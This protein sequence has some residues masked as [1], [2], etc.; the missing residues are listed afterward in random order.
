MNSLRI[1]NK[2]IY[3]IEVN[4]KGECIEFNLNDISNSIKFVEAL[5]DIE[6]LE[7][8]Y[9]DKMKNIQV[10][11]EDD[12][13]S[14]EVQENIKLEQE[15]FKEMRLAMDKVL[16]ENACQKIFGDRNYYEMFNDLIDELSRPREELNGKSHLDMINL[17]SDEIHKRIMNKYQKNKKATI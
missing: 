7:K 6:K 13:Q 3:K 5:K 15:M 16:G 12:F 1:E 14:K 9:T 10:Y 2:D 17:K 8:K 11:E 4:D